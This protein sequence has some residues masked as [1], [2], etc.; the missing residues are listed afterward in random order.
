MSLQPI[1]PNSEYLFD[2]FFIQEIYQHDRVIDS[3]FAGSASV[4]KQNDEKTNA[5]E[6]MEKR[7]K[8]AI[9]GAEAEEKRDDNTS[10]I[11]ASEAEGNRKTKAREQLEKKTGIKNKQMDDDEEDDLLNHWH[12]FDCCADVIM[13]LG[14]F[15]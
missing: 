1:S 15:A 2:V 14:G 13:G 8:M 11:A 4:E 5:S 3:F 10:E 9:G 12:R 6:E 7:E